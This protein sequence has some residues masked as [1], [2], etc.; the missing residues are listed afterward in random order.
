MHAYI[1]LIH[2]LQFLDRTCLCERRSY[3][4]ILCARY[5]QWIIW[6]LITQ[7]WFDWPERLWGFYNRYLGSLTNTHYNWT[8]GWEFE[9]NPWLPA[10]SLPRE[11]AFK[12]MQ[13]Y[14]TPGEAPYLSPA[15]LGLRTWDTVAILFR[16]WTKVQWP[17]YGRTQHSWWPIVV[18]PVG[19]PGLDFVE[20]EVERILCTGSKKDHREYCP[21]QL[22]YR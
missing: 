1:G 8:T 21:W 11:L 19:S 15:V 20:S 4:T 14:Y 12:Q 6:S 7:S 3:I 5:E 2:L 10:K 17:W 22:W 13:Y 18:G 9:L 16:A